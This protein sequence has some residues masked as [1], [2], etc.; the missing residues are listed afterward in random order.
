MQTIPSI[1]HSAGLFKTFF[2]FLMHAG[3]AEASG[4]GGQREHERE[5]DRERELEKACE[6]K[7]W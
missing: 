4:C 2:L 3:G 7:W 5:R 6:R 1:L